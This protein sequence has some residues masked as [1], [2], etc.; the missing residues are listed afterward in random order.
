[1]VYSWSF[2]YSM[3]HHF[4]RASTSGVA[5][6]GHSRRLCHCIRRSFLKDEDGLAILVGEIPGR[7]R[8]AFGANY[9][10]LVELKNKYDPTNLFRLN[11]NVKPN[12]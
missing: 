7:E 6:C 3:G 8:D 4:P 12:A 11:Q 2:G 9:D 10:R 1:M 5:E